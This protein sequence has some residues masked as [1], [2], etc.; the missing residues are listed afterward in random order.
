MAILDKRPHVDRRVEFA[1]A[2]TVQ[3]KMARENVEPTRTSLSS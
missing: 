2:T 3:I 1:P